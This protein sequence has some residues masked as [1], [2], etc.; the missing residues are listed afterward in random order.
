MA[1]LDFRIVFSFGVLFF[2]IRKVVIADCIINGVRLKDGD[3]FQRTCR[4]QCTCMNGVYACTSACPHEAVRPS[5]ECEKLELAEIPGQCCRE[6]MCL[7]NKIFEEPSEGISCGSHVDTSWS[8]CPAECGM[9]ISTRVT[10]RHQDCFL[11]TEVRICQ[12]RPCPGHIDF[13]DNYDELFSESSCMA[14]V[15][16]PTSIHLTYMGCVSRNRYS[17]KFCGRCK[18]RCC[19]PSQFRN[20]KI[21]FT[22]PDNSTQLYNYMYID[23]C[24]C[25]PC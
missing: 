11:A 25:E 19:H 23:E 22:C 24:Q 17:L 16:T 15:K 3:T 12:I 8:E 2:N 6:W 9:G 5:V 14:T 4:E 7:S 13:L 1:V 20:F 21:K 18:N 10:K